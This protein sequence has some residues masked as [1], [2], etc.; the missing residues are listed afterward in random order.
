MAEKYENKEDVV[1]LVDFERC[2][3][4]SPTSKLLSRRHDITTSTVYGHI[5]RFCE[6]QIYGYCFQSLDVMGWEYGITD[7]TVAKSLKKLEDDK[8]IYRLP[9]EERRCKYDNGDTIAYGINVM[10]IEEI[11]TETGGKDSANQDSDF[12]KK[13]RNKAERMQEWRDKKLR[14]KIEADEK[15]E[16]LERELSE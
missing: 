16:K 14:E 5:L 8:L 6:S 1:K 3:Y 15:I 12:M 10:R 13:R 7:K 4:Y 2:G 9:N 11:Y